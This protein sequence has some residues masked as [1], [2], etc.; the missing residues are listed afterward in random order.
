MTKFNLKDQSYANTCMFMHQG[1]RTE[2]AAHIREHVRINRFGYTQPIN[3]YIEQ[4]HNHKL[5][6]ADA[7]EAGT[8]GEY[9][10]R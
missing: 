7:V 1:N 4:F 2:A 9:S 5:A 8:L 6:I 10:L 3:G